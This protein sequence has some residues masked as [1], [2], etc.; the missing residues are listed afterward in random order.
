MPHSLV[1]LVVAIAVVALR[2]FLWF[3]QNFY[4][5]DCSLIWLLVSAFGFWFR[6]WVFGFVVILRDGKG[7]VGGAATRGKYVE[8]KV[9]KTLDY[10]K[11]SAQK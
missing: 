3:C 2:I 9:I 8:H 10:F 1:V 7:R 6:A 5:Q 4:A 11:R